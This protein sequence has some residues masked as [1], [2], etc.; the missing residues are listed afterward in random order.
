MLRLRLCPAV[1]FIMAA[2]AAAVASTQATLAEAAEQCRTKPDLSAPPGSHWYYRVD[3]VTQHRCWFLS[4]SD[5]RVHQVNPLRHREN[6]FTQRPELENDIT[7]GAARRESVVQS[8]EHTHAEQAVPEVAAL[9]S[10]SEDLPSHTITSISYTEPH[11]GEQD[12]GR[13]SENGLVFLWGAIATALLVAGVAFQLIGLIHRRPHMASP[14]TALQ[15]SRRPTRSQSSARSIRKIRNDGQ[16]VEPA[17]RGLETLG[18]GMAP[19][20]DA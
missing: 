7:G 6:A 17:D 8:V 18:Y 14:G 10:T 11:A 19:A 5:T 9:S 4:S 3:H 1:L 16:Q 20:N 15:T 12:R 2:A 13:A